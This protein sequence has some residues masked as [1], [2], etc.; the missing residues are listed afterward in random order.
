MRRR[1]RQ[2]R[3]I[4]M[5]GGTADEAAGTTPTAGEWIAVQDKATPLG[6]TP[7]ADPLEQVS[8]TEQIQQLRHAVGQLSQADQQILHL[9]HT[10]GLTFKQIAETL[11]QPLGT[12]LARGHRALAKLKDLIGPEPD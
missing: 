9:R 1:K 12:V 6:A 4:D 5:T 10:A 11:E 8:R 2:A 3:P 7:P